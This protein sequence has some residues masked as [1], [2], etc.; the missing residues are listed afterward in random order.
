[1]AHV[2]VA[3]GVDA[4][5]DLDLEMADIV[6]QLEVVEPGYTH[7]PIVKIVILVVIVGAV[8]YGVYW[9]RWGRYKSWLRKEG[10]IREG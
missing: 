2:M 8:G 5:R 7:I 9:F 1:M 6:L 4:A 10:S 3:T